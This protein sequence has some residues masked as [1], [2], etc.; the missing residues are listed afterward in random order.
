MDEK[1]CA[2]PGCTL[3]DFHAG[4]C[5]PHR[6]VGKR[7]PAPKVPYEEC[8]KKGRF[9]SDAGSLPRRRASD[10]WVQCNRCMKWRLHPPS[11]LLDVTAWY[12]ELHPDP[13]LQSC[14]APQLKE[15][16][17]SGVFYVDRLLQQRTG[18]KSREFLVRWLGWGPDN[19][20]WEVE[21]N[22]VDKALISAFNQLQKKPGQDVHPQSLLEEE[23]SQEGTR[24]D[25]MPWTSPVD[26]SSWV[27]IAPSG[28]CGNGVFARAELTPGQAICEYRGPRLPLHLQ[29]G[30]SYVL[31]IPQTGILID[32]NC[33]NS[34][35][36]VPRSPAIYVNHSSQPSKHPLGSNS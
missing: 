29:L 33:E 23:D 26:R 2:T 20:S 25:H 12:C 21:D 14:T 6:R 7:P 17:E 1:L 32:G 10:V 34:P 8:G 24:T 28:A 3:D 4:V 36:E 16:S 30:G 19:D 31:Q 27:F 11:S 15:T 13:A 5:M 9:R 22:I 35:F 18:K